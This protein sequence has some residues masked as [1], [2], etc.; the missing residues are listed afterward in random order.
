MK[1]IEGIIPPNGWHY[2]DRD[3]KI[4]GID[5]RDLVKNVQ[6]FRAENGLAFGDAEADISRYI[7]TNHP[8]FCTGTDGM[9]P[10]ST[11]VNLQQLMEDVGQWA[12]SLLFDKK[13]R[14]FVNDTEAER[15][16]LICTNCEF[17]KPWR[18]ACSSCVAAVERNSASVR[19]GRDTPTSRILGGCVKMRHDNRSAVFL[20]SDNFQDKPELPGNCWLA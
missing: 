12:K 19:E 6:R 8:R 1:P 13:T 14:G 7:C 18:A 3:V 10:S 5:F 17:N 20:D 16:A 15:R 2:Y 4:T 9:E 11:V